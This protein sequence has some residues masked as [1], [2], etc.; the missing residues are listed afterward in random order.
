MPRFTTL[1]SG[2]SGNC[3][4]LEAG[5]EFL[6]IDM[7]GSCRS[8]LAGLVAAGL[9]PRNLRGI[10]VTHEHTDHIKGLM[11]FLKKV[12]VPVLASAGTLDELRAGGFVP[13]D[14]ELVC[15]HSGQVQLGGF[16]ISSFATNHDAVASC[17]WR[18]EMGECAMALAT[19]LGEMTPEVYGNL[20]DA[21]FVALEA[22]YD[23]VMLQVGRYPAYLKRRIASASGHLSN[24][25]AAQTVA[26]LVA[27]GCRRVALCHLSAENN[28]PRLVYKAIE[29][30][31]LEHGLSMPA[32]C[33][34][35]VARRHEMSDWISF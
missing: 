30:A 18:I 24:R 27:C 14:A 26:R 15:V 25:D 22:N 29:D 21:A 10:L 20:E 6:L 16:G 1:Y 32:D 23:P 5:G 11:V 9:S 8:T 35:Q 4:V 34:V 17:G 2:S 7:G 3:A 33:V 13:E 19:D 28:Q 12:K 31:M